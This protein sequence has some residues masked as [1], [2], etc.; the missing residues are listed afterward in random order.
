MPNKSGNGIKQI[1]FLTAGALRFCGAPLVHVITWQDV[2][3]AFPV[4]LD[5]RTLCWQSILQCQYSEKI[6]LKMLVCANLA[7]L[8]DYPWQG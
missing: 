3:M 7:N 4:S 2:T 5:C 8:P 6:I 1:S